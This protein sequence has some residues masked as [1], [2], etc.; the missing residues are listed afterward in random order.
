MDISLILLSFILVLIP[1]IITY[2]L[3]IGIEKEILKNSIRALLQLTALGFILGFLFKIKNP[4]FYVPIVLFMLLYS[5]YIAKKRTNY[6]FIAAFFS[7][8][9]ATTLILTILVSLKII[10]LKPNE[11]IP[12]AG[13]IIGNALNTYT[14]T[15]ERLKREITLQKELIEAF[16]A[17]GAR[18][19]DALKIMQKEAIKA[20]LIPVN[21]MLQT[22][23]VVAIP[24]ITT[25]MLLAGASPLKAVTYQIVIIYMLVSIN[26]FSSLFG[27]YFYIKEKELV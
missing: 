24:G 5:S 6:S 1:S 17:I 19:S 18:Y 2:K 15:I 11:F 22:I 3:K 25:G 8:T 23:G 14:L 13:M 20:A 12:I 4:I 10:S 7:L 16:I 9:L 27:S 26:L 21:N